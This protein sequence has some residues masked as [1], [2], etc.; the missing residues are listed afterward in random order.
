M[1][2]MQAD[3]LRLFLEQPVNAVLATQQKAGWPYLAPVWFLWEGTGEQAAEYPHYEHGTFWLTGT[4]NRQ[5]C[6]NLLSD[7]HVSLCMEHGP[8]PGYVAVG[9]VA[10]PLRPD[11]FDIWPV[12]ERLVAKY[13]GARRGPAAAGKFLSNMRTEPRMLFRLTPKS[14]RAI[15]LTVYTGTRADLA[16]Q[17]RVRGTR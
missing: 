10:E 9:C 15:D 14:W 5:W 3:V 6:K 11:Q 4:M 17:E 1:A 16:H 2:R 12:S 13:V 8:V 7:P